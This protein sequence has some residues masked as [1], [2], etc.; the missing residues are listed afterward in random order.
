MGCRSLDR[1]GSKQSKLV[2]VSGADG[3]A[4][5]PLGA[6][7]REHCGATLGLHAATEAMGFGATAAV[8]LKCA[9]R[10]LDAFLK[11]LEKFFRLFSTRLPMQLLVRERR[12]F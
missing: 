3:D 10:H 5:A 1:S 4:L 7:A 11:F 9:L 6:A 12:N 2:A 8:G